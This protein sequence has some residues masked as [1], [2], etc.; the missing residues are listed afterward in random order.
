MDSDEQAIRALFDDWIKATVVGDL[1]LARDCIADDA[2]FLVPGFG[3]MNKEDFAQAAA[4]V[5]P[6]E[7]PIAY[8]LDSQLR[9]VEV[10]GDHAHLWVD[11]KLKMTPKA[12]GP[13]SWMAGSSLSILVKRGGRWWIYRDMNTL[14]AVEE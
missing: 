13:D 11:S 6:E 9:E 7:S 1:G 4:G 12:G 14:M 2:V 8:D 10:Y 5:P 3:K